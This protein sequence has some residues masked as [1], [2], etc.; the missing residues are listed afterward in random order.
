METSTEITFLSTLLPMVGVVFIIAVGVVLLNQQFQKNLYKQQLQQ[1]ELKNLHQ[2]ELLNSSIQVQE[3][4]RKR[5]AQD[6]HD[7]LG[8][9]LAIS[10]MHLVQLEQLPEISNQQTHL[11]AVQQVRGLTE[12]ALA[13]MRRISHELMPPQL[14]TFGLIKTLEAVVNRLNETSSLHISICSDNTLAELNWPIQLGLYRISME[15]INNTIKYAQATQV[16]IHFNVAA[17]QL[18]YGYEDNG[19]GMSESSTSAGLGHKSILGRVNAM[20][21]TI[22]MSNQQ[23]GGFSTTIIIPLN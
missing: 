6:L 17:E 3:D 13:S 23:H 19:I 2:L 7:E 10:R 11:Q 20:G 15:L 21:G 5:I 1:E 12:N 8:A 18:N 16:S 4:E 9:I 14:Q 22:K